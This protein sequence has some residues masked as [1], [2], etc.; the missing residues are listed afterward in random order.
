MVAAER[1]FAHYADTANVPAAFV[2][3]LRDDAI[4]LDG[5]GVKQ[6]KPIYAARRP[7][8]AWLRWAPS[9]ADAAADGSMGFT[10]GPWAWHPARDSA[11]Q[12]HGNFMTIWV[13]GADRWQVA[14]DLGVDGDTT[15]HL[16]EPLRVQPAGT[17]GRSRL[18]DLTDLE[19]NRI[20][21][22][23][24]LRTLRDLAAPDVRVLRDGVARAEGRD[25]LTG[26]G[27]VRFTPLGGRVATSGDIGA[28][29]GTWVDGAKKGSYVRFWRNT[30]QGWRVTVDRLGD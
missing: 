11:A 23:S 12:G 1:G 8:P 6:M 7:G 13:K 17:A 21:G 15:A 29:W 25:G 16:D 3:A 4:T 20:K 5:T 18:T 19:K 9:W 27:S 10:T 22:G 24:W 28:T 2:W 14:L 26:A 30:P